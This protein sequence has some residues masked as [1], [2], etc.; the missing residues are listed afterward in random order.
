MQ[1]L[2]TDKH[3]GPEFK[4]LA[5]HYLGHPIPVIGPN[6]YPVAMVNMEE[7]GYCPLANAWLSKHFQ[8]RFEG[9]DAYFPWAVQQTLERMAMLGGVDCAPWSWPAHGKYPWNMTEPERL[10]VVDH[11]VKVVELT[12]MKA[13]FIRAYDNAASAVPSTS[14]IEAHVQYVRAAME[15]GSMVRDR[16]GLPLV[17]LVWRRTLGTDPYKSCGFGR[18]LAPEENEPVFEEIAKYN[19]NAVCD[20]TSEAFVNYAHYTQVSDQLR[21]GAQFWSF[22][23]FP[24]KH[25]PEW[26]DADIAYLHGIDALKGE[27]FR[28]Q[29]VA[30]FK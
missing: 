1:L 28:R 27:Q 6:H 16:T 7:K 8:L 3:A 19:P 20:W 4:R 2:S 22:S 5:I 14:N 29:M 15:W 24:E 17:P 25:Y 30:A 9:T 12:G 23:L 11:S 18:Y 13:L 26:N 21:D 10:A